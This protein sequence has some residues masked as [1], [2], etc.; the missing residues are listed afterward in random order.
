MLSE[1]TSIALGCALL[2]INASRSLALL[3]VQPVRLASVNADAVFRI[4][5]IALWSQMAVS[6]RMHHSVFLTTSHS[7]HHV[8]TIILFILVIIILA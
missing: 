1:G 3:T 2:K 4:A 5:N 8:L 6:L 7:T